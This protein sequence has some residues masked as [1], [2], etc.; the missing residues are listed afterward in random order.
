M[1]TIGVC[2]SKDPVI[3]KRLG[4]PTKDPEVSADHKQ[5]LRADQRKRNE[6]ERCFESGQRKY[7]LDLILVRL[8]KVQRP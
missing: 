4:R 6:V 3:G 8:I 7:S 1:E 2:S 5:Q